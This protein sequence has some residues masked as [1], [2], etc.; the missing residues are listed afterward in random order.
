MRTISRLLGI[1]AASGWG[2]ASASPVIDGREFDR[3]GVIRPQFGQSCTA[4]RAL[5]RGIGRCG[6]IDR[7]LW[8]RDGG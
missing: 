8:R 7:W 5:E 2:A 4:A 6:D 1:D 3:F